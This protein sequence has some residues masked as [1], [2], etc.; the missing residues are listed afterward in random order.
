MRP[1]RS[2]LYMPGSNARAL[3]KARSLAADAL[4]LDLEDA[5]APDAKPEGRRL[6]AEAV[7]AGGYGKR[8]LM[9]RI[10]GLDTE[11]GAD[12]IAEVAACKPDATL[13][14]K[15]NTP[16][17]LHAALAIMDRHGNLKETAIWAMMETP[18]GI[19]GAAEIARATP[20]LAGFVLGTND[21]VKDMQARHD[22]TRIAVQSSLS[23]CIL[24][25]RA[26]GIVVVDGVFNDI[27]DTDGLAAEC[28]QGRLMGFDGKT[29]IH[30]GQ[31][32]EANAAFAPSE[33]DLAQ[34]H[35]FVE[36]F[37][38]AMAEGKAVAVVGGRIVENL[39]VE[40]ARR[41]IAQADAI[42]AMEQA[43]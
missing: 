31:I 40:N 23:I 41:L 21:L 11:W 34:A 1:F 32:E 3:E 36:A 7:N 28:A 43:T 16:D 38:A 4:I 20:R 9:V 37:E 22:P 42:T 17:D 24:A 13:L 2:V 27:R 10:N 8:Y 12:D 39:H 19:L 6:I 35:A 29:L 26:A 18:Q 5:C 33:A 25:A 30:P 14:P 15:V